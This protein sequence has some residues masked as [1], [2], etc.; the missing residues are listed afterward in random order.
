[1]QHNSELL[2]S[3]LTK[4]NMFKKLNYT[5]F[6]PNTLTVRKLGR[7]IA[8]DNCKP[9]AS[10]DHRIHKTVN[11]HKDMQDALALISP[12]GPSPAVYA[13]LAGVID[14]RSS[15]PAANV[16]MSTHRSIRAPYYETLQKALNQERTHLS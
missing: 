11:E 13:G 16:T 7:K 14:K 12:K 15:T 1:M 5:Q 6:N 10:Q 8:V 3:D 2:A 4:K 9:I